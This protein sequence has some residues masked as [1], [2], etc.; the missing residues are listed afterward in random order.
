MKYRPGQAGRTSG[1]A[2]ILPIGKLRPGAGVR[3]QTRRLDIAGTRVFHRAEDG[4]RGH[5]RPRDTRKGHKVTGKLSGL[6]SDFAEKV[7]RSFGWARLPTVAAI[8]ILIGLRDRLRE[9]NLYDTGRGPLDKPPY[10]TPT[11]PGTS[12][13]GTIDGTYNDLDDPLDGLAGKPVRAQRA[14]RARLSGGAASGCSSPN[15]RLDQPAAA[16]ARALPAGDDAQP[17]GRRLDPV[18]GARLAEPR[19]RAGRPLGDPAREGRSVARAPDEDPADD[20]RP[21]PRPDRA[22]DLRHRRHPLVGRIAGVRRQA[23]LRRRTA[24]RTRR[25]GSASTTWACPPEDLQKFA[26]LSGVAGNFW[27]GLAILHSLFMREHNAICERLARGVSGDV[28]PGALRQGAAGERRAHGQDPH[29]R[30]DAGDHRPPDHRPCAADELVRASRRAS[31]RRWSGRSPT[32]RCSTASP[33][34]R[35]TT[36]AC[37][38]R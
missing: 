23:G 30:L 24:I 18:R 27:V 7:D 15:P 5:S 4:E 10:R 35:R 38:T 29:R 6:V 36:T 1:A 8:P 9:K 17:A 16:H 2:P 20:A 11:S 31:P 12:A 22:A 26:D 14:A 34:R 25:D 13:R 37:P 3:C 32:T 21:E 33:A 19:P 28:R